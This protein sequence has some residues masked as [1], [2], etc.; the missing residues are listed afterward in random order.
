M[1]DGFE[2]CCI[3]VKFVP[4]ARMMVVSVHGLVSDKPRVSVLNH[5]VVY[6]YASSEK[7]AKLHFEA[8]GIFL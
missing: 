7:L 2:S 4:K 6:P 8:A 1:R 3:H 5:S